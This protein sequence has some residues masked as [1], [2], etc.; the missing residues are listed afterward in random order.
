MA[1]EA[2]R[3]KARSPGNGSKPEVNLCGEIH[4]SSL[5]ES[6]GLDEL[7]VISRREHEKETRER[8]GGL[9]TR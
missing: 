9:A 2:R 3:G 5:D 8:L 7:G 4:K 6:E 1:E